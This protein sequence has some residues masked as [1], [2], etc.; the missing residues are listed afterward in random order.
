MLFHPGAACTF[1]DTT[2]VALVVAVTVLSASL[3]AMEAWIPL[4][5]EVI[6][7]PVEI[8]FGSND[9]DGDSFFMPKPMV[10]EDWMIKDWMPF[11]C[12]GDRREKA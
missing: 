2:F 3:V 8:F 4:P 5:V 7:S 10:A 12:S 9:L 6:F 11:N 1:L